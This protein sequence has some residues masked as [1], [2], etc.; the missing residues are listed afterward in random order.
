MSL[1][2]H[3]SFNIAY[4]DGTTKGVELVLDNYGQRKVQGRWEDWDMARRL[5]KYVEFLASLEISGVSVLPENVAS[6]TFRF[7][8]IS[9]DNSVNV[10]GGSS[11]LS[12]QVISNNLSAI[13]AILKA[14]DAFMDAMTA[15]VP[16]LLLLTNTTYVDYRPY[17]IDSEV[18]NLI[19][20]LE[21]FN[22]LEYKEFT[23]I[24]A[25]GLQAVLPGANKLLIPESE[26]SPLVLS[27]EA[28]DALANWVSE[29]NT[30]IVSAL[31]ATW[32][33]QFN[34]IFDF[35]VSTAGGEGADFHAKSPEAADTVYSNAPNKLFMEDATSFVDTNSLPLGSK[36]VY[37]QGSSS[38]VTILPFGDGKIYL[39]GYDW[40]DAKPYGSQDGGWIEILRLAVS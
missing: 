23:D 5:P 26:V 34:T 30:L 24:S 3:V 12:P 28:Q 11:I 8:A 25:A 16:V 7:S 15:N 1:I 21:T 18:W 13:T 35:S 31:S 17:D 32:I 2:W 22:G 40:Y 39:L 29:G 14:N 9:A 20:G 37:Y 19:K 6:Y 36:S 10:L 33:A 4:K 38:S 27:A